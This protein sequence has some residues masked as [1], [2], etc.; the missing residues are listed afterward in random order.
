M[1]KWFTNLFSSKESTKPVESI[2]PQSLLVTEGDGPKVRDYP[3]KDYSVYWEVFI[4]ESKEHGYKATLRFMNWGGGVVS[5]SVFVNRY[6]NDLQTLVD[7]AIVS[8]MPKF[9]RS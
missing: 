8:K 7:H 5:E 9:R 3:K 1:I 4:E 2:A 6:R